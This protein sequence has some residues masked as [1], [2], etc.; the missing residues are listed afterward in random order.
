MLHRGSGV[1]VEGICFVEEFW[2]AEVWIM[3]VVSRRKW[4]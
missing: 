4:P 1:A 3:R 2:D